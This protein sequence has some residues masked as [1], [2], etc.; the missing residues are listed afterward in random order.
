MSFNIPP[1]A[2]ARGRGRLRL[3]DRR[4][5]RLLDGGVNEPRG[6]CHVATFGC[7]VNQADSEA[8]LATL[9]ER[10]LAISDS[11]GDADLVVINSCTVTHRSDADLRKL[12]HRIQRTNPK[13]K[14]VV[15]GCG[16]QRDPEALVQ[17]GGASAILGQAHR[18]ELGPLVDRLLH[19][20]PAD[21]PEV[22]WSSLED[23][24]PSE[25]PPVEV[26]AAVHD[27][28]RPFVK[29]QDGCD[30]SCT[31]CVIPSV[32]G[33]ARSAEGPRILEAVERLIGAG[34]FEVVIAGVHLG[35]WSGG[36]DLGSLI[37]RILALPG[38]G[39]L[40]L[41][42]IEP[43]AF[44]RSLIELAARD[45]RLAPHFHLPL[46]SGSDRVLKRMNR[47]YRSSDYVE[48]TRAIRAQLPEVCLGADVITGFPGETEE[49]FA[50]SLATAEAAGLD[51]LHAFS[52]SD[53]PGVP[54]TRLKDKIDP[55]TIKARTGRLI[56]WSRLAW[57]RFLDRRIG[58][59]LEAVTLERDPERPELIDALAADYAPL[60]AA[61]RSLAVGA[62]L[63]FKILAREGDRL[64]AT[65]VQ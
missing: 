39:R 54:S 55:A 56:A 19:G 61:D 50:A 45:P 60:R 51:Y 12:I 47:P 58:R 62:N 3:L 15:A 57:S 38:L 14:V 8:M 4:D 42:A 21:R 20:A 41:S 59:E 7:R 26:V 28:T 37:E 63:R 27:R 9:S 65:A 16:A 36:G 64:W 24:D 11:F 23:R 30:A 25:L 2:S 31:Y 17:L 10:G 35:T 34:H 46:Q 6:R 1:S 53:R 32:R 18:G 33:P 44:P 5:P 52:Y 13:A 40:R 49:D 43:M 48:L 29:I 22:H